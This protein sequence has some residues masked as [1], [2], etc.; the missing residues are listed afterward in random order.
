MQIKIMATANILSSFTM[1]K[2]LNLS[3]KAGNSISSMIRS[4]PTSCIHRFCNCTTSRST[5]IQNASLS[6]SH[7]S[8]TI[9][10]LNTSYSTGHPSTSRPRLRSGRG[11]TIPSARGSAVAMPACHLVA[12]PPEL[13]SVCAGA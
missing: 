13:L 6:R 4:Q 11:S 7:Q 5:S 8:I 9:S 3:S 2:R 10:A 1:T 12:A